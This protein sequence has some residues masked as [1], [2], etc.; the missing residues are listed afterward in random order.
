LFND[1]HN[2]FPDD[3]LVS[4]KVGVEMAD[5]I[6]TVVIKNREKIAPPIVWERN[7]IYL[8][9]IYAYNTGSHP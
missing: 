7:A 8:E 6:Q 5:V 1:L 4:K 3:E 9:G 2:A